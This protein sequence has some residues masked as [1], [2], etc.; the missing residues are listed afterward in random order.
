MTT[1]SRRTLTTASRSLVRTEHRPQR[2]FKNGD[3]SRWTLGWIDNQASMFDMSE[4][5]QNTVPANHN[6]ISDNSIYDNRGL[7]IDLV[8]DVDEDGDDVLDHGVGCDPKS[9]PINPN[10]CIDFPVFK[11]KQAFAMLGR[12][13]SLCNV[14]IFRVD[15]DP[16]DNS[17]AD[18]GH[19]EGVGSKVPD[20][21]YWQ[22]ARRTRMATHIT[23]P[24]GLGAMDLTA[25]ATDKV[26]GERFCISLARLVRSDIDGDEHPVPPTTN[27]LL[28]TTPRRTRRFRRPTRRPT[29]RRRRH[30]PGLWRRERQ[31]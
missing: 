18:P 30:R 28:P 31:R 2:I 25:T 19:G 20:H 27:T 8:A 4:N 17:K 12:A 23:L 11:T 21:Y 14:E 29:R 15:D 5:V 26:K 9:D 3:D 24:C 22:R 16:A 13:C 10:D 7:G 6:R 1:S